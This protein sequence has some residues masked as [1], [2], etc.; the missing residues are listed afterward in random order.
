MTSGRSVTF[1]DLSEFVTERA[2]VSS[3]PYGL[4]F[5]KESKQ[6]YEKA[7]KSKPQTQKSGGGSKATTLA[8]SNSERSVSEQAVQCDG[9]RRDSRNK[10]KCY[11][12][13]GKCDKL[14]NC[15]K[16]KSFSL[17]ERRQYVRKNRL[18]FNCL[19][20][21]HVVKDCRK[22]NQCSV[23]GCDRK[24]NTLLHQWYKSPTVDSSN[25]MNVQVSSVSDVPI[26][27]GTCTATGSNQK[28]C[29]RILPVRIANGDKFIETYALLD[30]GSE[31]TLCDERVVSSLG[32]SAKSKTYTINSINKSSVIKGAEVSLNVTSLDGTGKSKYRRRGLCQNYRY[33]YGVCRVRQILVNGHT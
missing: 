8:T 17:D 31:V 30:D 3:T 28:V 12:C 1:A 24:H 7:N 19:I 5:A 15:S 22:S 27:T 21:N 4:H 18:C 23:S 33:H 20:Y 32:L 2:G 14:F 6:N 13:N 26:Q 11:C 29:L 25:T 16:F 9:S 10:L